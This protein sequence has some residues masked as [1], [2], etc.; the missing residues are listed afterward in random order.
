[1]RNMEC[2]VVFCRKSL[3]SWSIFSLLD[4]ICQG[5]SDEIA[6]LPS[7]QRKYQLKKYFS[8]VFHSTKILSWNIDKGCA[9]FALVICRAVSHQDHGFINRN[10]NH[11]WASR[12]GKTAKMAGIHCFKPFAQKAFSISFTNISYVVFS[13]SFFSSQNIINLIRF[14]L[15]KGAQR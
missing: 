11:S 7:F 6:P 2:G 15:K 1:M 12:K 13:I 4:S 10:V 5:N 3:P 14:L 8:S 9:D